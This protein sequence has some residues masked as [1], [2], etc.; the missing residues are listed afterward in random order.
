MLLAFINEMHI[1][2]YVVEKY[3]ENMSHENGVSS[4][5]TSTKGL[6]RPTL[7]GKRRPKG[8]IGHWIS[9]I[10]TN[11]LATQR[12]KYSGVRHERYL[13][14]G[15]DSA[16]RGGFSMAAQSTSQQRHGQQQQQQHRPIQ[17]YWR[18][19]SRWTTIG[20]SYNCCVATHG[21]NTLPNPQRTY[22]VDEGSFVN[23]IVFVVSQ[24]PEDWTKTTK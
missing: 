21:F 5:S 4:N 11:I 17:Y 22:T 3:R 24:W 6:D 8:C 16:P 20:G 10:K 23:I 12:Q 2:R 15:D 13:V 19:F 7:D 1:C 9:L 14:N 18:S